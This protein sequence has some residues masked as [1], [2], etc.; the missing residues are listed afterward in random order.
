MRIGVLDSLP[1]YGV[2]FGIVLLILFSF[3]V[4]YQISKQARKRY[5]KDMPS[6]LGPMVAGLLSMLA[7]ILAFTF[8]I[9][10]AQ[11]E[12]RK[13]MVLNEANMI[14]TAYMR[15]DLLDEK[16]Q[17]EVKSLLRD[18]VNSRL[19]AINSDKFEIEITKAV[20]LHKFLWAQVSSAAEKTPNTNTSLLVQ[21]INNVIDMHQNRL[22]AVVS[23]RVSG[24]IWLTLLII[25]ALTMVTVG[26]QAGYSK[27]RRLIAIF[28][29]ALAFAAL[30]T[31]IADLDH[32]QKGLIK[33]GQQAMTFL[34]SS[35]N[36]DIN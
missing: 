32:P 6:T 19:E 2:Y 15:A 14:G 34:Q 10:A 12:N 11:Y 21:S 7:F 22:M 29:M 13:Q 18:Y 36:R 26:F 23:N 28:P 33:V 27:S 5:N 24:S 30:T 9:A 16:R 35:M 4:G 1:V 25:S 8:S 3:E 17:A 31:V 20:E